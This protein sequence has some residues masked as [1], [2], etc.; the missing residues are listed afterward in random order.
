MASSAQQPIEQGLVARWCFE[1][2]LS[3]LDDT[4]PFGKVKD[5]LLVKGGV[6]FENGIAKLKRNQPS[7]LVASLSEDPLDMKPAVSC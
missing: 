7:G 2:G 3:P 1:T 6:N 5:K 4:A